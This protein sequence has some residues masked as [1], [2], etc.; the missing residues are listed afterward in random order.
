MPQKIAKNPR[1]SIKALLYNDLCEYW[2]VM[3]IQLDR[4]KEPD[5]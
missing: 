1:V 5:R 2:R 3:A 4:I